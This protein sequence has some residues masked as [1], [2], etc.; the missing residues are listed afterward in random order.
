MNDQL[1]EDLLRKSPIPQPPADLVQ[2]L[3][4]DIRLPRIQSGRSESCVPRSLFRRWFPAL[5]FS[6][7]VI[8]CFVVMAVQANL[9]SALKHGNE[10]LRAQTRN[11]DALR[12][13]NVEAQRLRGENSDLASL[14]RDNSELQR[15]RGEMIQLQTQAASL[16]QLR[17]DH[18]KLAASAGSASGAPVDFFAEAKAKAQ[19]IACVNNLKE[20]GL[21]I[22][23]WAS[24]NNGQCPPNFIS[25]TNELGQTWRILHCPSD[26]SDSAANW[27]DI[28][29]GKTSYPLYTAGCTDT[30]DPNTI[31]AECPIHHNILLLDGSVQ[32]L[33]AK[34][35]A[36]QIKIVNGRKV[37]QR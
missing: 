26:D 37:W 10:S 23:L 25:M 21:A 18:Q 24:D 34:T 28:E 36:E 27:A 17:A 35:Y 9:I 8:A 6:A 31:V 20:I 3:V 12:Q 22:T 11:L 2:R 4:A 15:L 5:T 30:N 33:S 1:I 32:Q 7:L 13:A 16:S 29:A 19:R 14:Q